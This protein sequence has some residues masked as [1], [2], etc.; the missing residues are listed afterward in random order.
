VTD[1][2]GEHLAA[3]DIWVENPQGEVTTPG[4]AIVALPSRAEAGG[5]R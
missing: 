1:R 4:T 3:L 2:D 5:G